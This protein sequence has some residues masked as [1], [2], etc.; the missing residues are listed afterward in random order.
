MMIRIQ[1]ESLR[2]QGKRFLE[3]TGA[4]SQE[5]YKVNIYNEDQFSFH[6]QSILN[7]NTILYL[8]LL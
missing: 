1:L 3:V 7:H 2:N 4:E 8:P 5:C 6:M